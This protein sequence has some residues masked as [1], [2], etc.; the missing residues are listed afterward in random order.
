MKFFY[1]FVL[2]ILPIVS[3]AQ[4]HLGES[5]TGLKNRYPDLTFEV[6]TTTDGTVYTTAQQLLGIFIYYFDSETGLTNLCVQIPDDLQALK[7]QVEIYN[8]KYVII[9]ENSWKAYL[10]GGNTMNINLMYNDEYETYL[11]YYTY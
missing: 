6:Q 5:Y 8:K 10:D 9:S 7:T 3:S 4:A 11:F 1:L 2:L